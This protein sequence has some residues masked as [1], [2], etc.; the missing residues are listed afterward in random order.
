L[1][2]LIAWHGL[3]TKDAAHVLKC[4]SAALAVRLYRARRRLEKA[5][6]AA[7]APDPSETAPARAAGTP[8]PHCEGAPA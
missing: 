3:S 8:R 7:Q 1:L 2:T 6:E 5:L 4:T